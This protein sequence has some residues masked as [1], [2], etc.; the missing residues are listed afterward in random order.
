[1]ISGSLESILVSGP[2]HSEGLAIDDVRVAT[3]GD[4]SG[5]F[6]GD[7]FLVSVLCYLGAI[8]ELESITNIQFRFNQQRSTTSCR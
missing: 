3:P 1:M 2:S 6:F 5:F 7:L 8:G 4:G